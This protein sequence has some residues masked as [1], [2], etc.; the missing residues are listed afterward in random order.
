MT[1]I[2][3]KS[4]DPY[5]RRV[6]GRGDEWTVHYCHPS[7]PQTLATHA[8]SPGLQA[9]CERTKHASLIVLDNS[10]QKNDVVSI[11]GMMGWTVL[12]AKG[13][14]EVKRLKKE[15]GWP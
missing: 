10:S 12:E 1:A 4:P 7:V 14:S 11:A 3:V 2:I 13:Y 8:V 15:H 6:D 5:Q 9:A